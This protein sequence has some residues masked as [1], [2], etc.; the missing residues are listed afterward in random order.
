MSVC[1]GALLLDGRIAGVISDSKLSYV[2]AL[3]FVE[4]V[5]VL[6]HPEYLCHHGN[7]NGWSLLDL[8]KS[9]IVS[10]SLLNCVSEA[11]V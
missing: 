6:E 8:N 3:R 9:E 7:Q 4:L 1:L 11:T 2:C 5:G 10:V